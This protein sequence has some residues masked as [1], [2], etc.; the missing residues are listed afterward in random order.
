MPPDCG[1]HLEQEFRRFKRQALHAA[2]L[3]LH[4]PVTGEYLR[5]GTAVAGR[6]ASLMEALAENEQQ[7]STFFPD[8]PAPANIMRLPHCEPAV[9]VTARYA[10][11]N[12][13]RMSA[14][15]LNR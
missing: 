10:S 15:M 4:H 1:E 6:Y 11:L 13:P 7:L 9:S 5:M 14:I 2:K 8:W 3:G 12:P